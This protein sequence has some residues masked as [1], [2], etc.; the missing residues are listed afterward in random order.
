LIFGGLDVMTMSMKKLE[1]G[2]FAI[3]PTRGGD[4]VVAFHH[5]LSMFKVQSTPGAAAA[6]PLE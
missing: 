1:V 6:L 2:G 3:S 4:D 5:V